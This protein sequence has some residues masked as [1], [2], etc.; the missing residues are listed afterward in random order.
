MRFYLI[1][2]TFFTRA[3]IGF[4]GLAPSS[5][6]AMDSLITRLKLQVCVLINPVIK[7]PLATLA[8]V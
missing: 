3:R 6:I 5:Y 1:K 2:L 7:N 8:P 4:C